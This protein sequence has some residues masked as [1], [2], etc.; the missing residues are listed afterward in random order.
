MV[1]DPSPTQSTSSPV[2]ARP[3]GSYPQRVVDDGTALLQTSGG[4]PPASFATTLAFLVLVNGLCGALYGF[5]IG[6]VAIYAHYD[7]ISRNCTAASTEIACSALRGQDSAGCLWALTPTDLPNLTMAGTASGNVTTVA[8]TAAVSTTTWTPKSYSCQFP[9]DVA[10]NSTD[11]GRNCAAATNDTTCEAL[12]SKCT[13]DFN[14]KLCKHV[15]GLSAIEN[16]L[17]AASLMVGAVIGCL[18]VPLMMTRCPASVGFGPKWIVLLS[19]MEGV[20]GS[21]LVNVARGADIFPLLLIGR[22]IAGLGVGSCTIG[23]TLYVSRHVPDR[24]RN[25]MGLLFQV[26]LCLATA[27]ASIYGVA[28]DPS[29]FDALTE[30][31]RM[32]VRIQ[33]FAAL[34]ALFGFFLIP[35]ACTMLPEGEDGAPD[36]PERDTSS[37]AHLTPGTSPCVTAAEPELPTGDPSSVNRPP[38]SATGQD[39]GYSLPL[40]Q[41]RHLLSERQRLSASVVSDL[42]GVPDPTRGGDGSVAESDSK[43]PPGTEPLTP[44]P[45]VVAVFLALALQLTGINAIMNYAPLIMSAAHLSPMVGNVLVMN[46]NFI[47]TFLSIPASRYLSGRR[48]FLIGV[49]VLSSACFVT[50][51]PMYPDV[52]SDTVRG[53]C[54]L[55]GVAL[56]ILAF[57]VGVGPPF[58]VLST[59]SFKKTQRAAASSITQLTQFAVI[60]MI[61]FGFPVAVQGISGGP[62]KDQFRG[63]SIVF[64][65]FGACGWCSWAVLYKTLHPP[66]VGEDV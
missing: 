37:R 28:V 48:L 43:P 15:A 60:I 55:V 62:S 64:V 30:D 33:V 39:G 52:A 54:N 21:L 66:P 40:L 58:Y 9:D 34:N 24:Y 38:S 25:Q 6:F 22:V 56:F 36:A 51:I 41:E 1:N 44:V 46:W 65:I 11:L 42:R 35:L 8:T 20:V 14:A 12:G 31:P 13:F 63:L 2:A 16:G 10:N 29:N 57:E 59:E 19:G 5:S 61:N 32:E 4:R 7:T 50:A 53:I 45:V 3:R 18:T 23:G 17:L 47:T 49:A 26:V 27:I